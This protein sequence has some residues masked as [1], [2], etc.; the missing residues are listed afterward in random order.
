MQRC[1]VRG[2]GAGE[3]GCDWHEESSSFAWSV[4]LSVCLRLQDCLLGKDSPVTSSWMAGSQSCEHVTAT[5][6]AA[7]VYPEQRVCENRY[8]SSLTE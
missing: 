2:A 6:A 3:R 8:S 5:R 1:G 4:C 7:M